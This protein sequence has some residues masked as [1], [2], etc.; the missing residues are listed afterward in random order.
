MEKKRRA[1]ATTK[2]TV[3]VDPEVHNLL[4]LYS[5][6]HELTLSSAIAKLIEDCAPDVLE[7]Q[8]ELDA[9]NSKH[10]RTK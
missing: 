10:L 8:R 5:R 3:K 4:V 6:K 2:T 9:L 1:P 7:W